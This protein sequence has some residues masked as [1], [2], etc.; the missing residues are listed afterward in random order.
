MSVLGLPAKRLLVLDDLPP[1]SL[2]GR[3]DISNIIFQNTA[4]VNLPT[5]GTLATPTTWAEASVISGNPVFNQPIQQGRKSW[6]EGLLYIRTGS[7]GCQLGIG[8]RYFKAGSPVRSTGILA[9]CDIRD[10][11][12]FRF[13]DET[14]G[15]EADE[16]RMI[17]IASGTAT[18]GGGSGSSPN[19]GLWRIIS[20]G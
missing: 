14:D 4:S 5:T 12:A 6:I 13:S 2:Q 3:M 11:A 9:F 1:V 20:F 17:L 7:S 15:A 8:L 16:V 10:L 19:G 18:F